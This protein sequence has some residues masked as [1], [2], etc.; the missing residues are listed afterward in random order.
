LILLYLS[1]VSTEALH[2]DLGSV[3]KNTAKVP[4]TVR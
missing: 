4:D 1:P 3:F 2:P